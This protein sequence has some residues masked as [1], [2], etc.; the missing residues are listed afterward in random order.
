MLRTTNVKLITNTPNPEEILKEAYGKCY[1]K[2]VK[3]ETIVK[4]LKHS[5]VLEH[6]TFTFDVE[7]SRVCWEQI[8]RHRL[9]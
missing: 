5:S 6:V 9:S 7:C 8:V 4:H 3:L 1:Q 2:E